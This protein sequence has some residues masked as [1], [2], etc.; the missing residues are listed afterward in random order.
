MSKNSGW[1]IGNI[2]KNDL[3]DQIRTLSIY[4]G[5]V[6]QAGFSDWG[7]RQIICHLLNAYRIC[8]LEH[9]K[10]KFRDNDE[11]VKEILAEFRENGPYWWDHR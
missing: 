5:E 4:L 10:E 6:A 2:A 7:K 1:S 9:G 8:D 3:D 11:M